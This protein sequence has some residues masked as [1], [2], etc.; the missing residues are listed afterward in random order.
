[1]EPSSESDF[2]APRLRTNSNNSF[3]TRLA[4]K[5]ITSMIRMQIKYQ[6]KEAVKQMK[7]FQ[8]GK[9]QLGRYIPTPAAV[10]VEM[11]E[12]QFMFRFPDGQYSEP[13]SAKTA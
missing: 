10:G 5:Q 4:N 9:P 2:A 1:M 8:K 6:E 3:T 7:R 13:P 12:N 11:L